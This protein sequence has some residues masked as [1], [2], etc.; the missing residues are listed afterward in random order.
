MTMTEEAG[1]VKVEQDHTVISRQAT[2]PMTLIEVALEQ[3]ADVEKLERLWELQQR[4]EANEAK[5]AF[6]AAM[7]GFRAECPSISKNATVSYGNG[8][9]SYKH[10]TLDHIIE[11]IKPTLSKFGLSHSWRVDQ[12]D[13]AIAVTCVVTHMQGHSEQTCMIGTPDTSG[14]KNAIQSIGSTTTYL[15][16]YTLTSLLGLA[17]GEDDDGAQSSSEP[18]A[19]VE[20][21][22]VAMI[23]S[24]RSK[25]ELKSLWANMTDEQRR[26]YH[27]EIKA[28]TS[29][30]TG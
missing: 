28:R 12:K 17:T 23:Q 2:T 21:D 3:N 8:R 24:A 16:R 14:S 20:G 19:G 13:G 27:D 30:L 9:T 6:D 15:Q 26:M 7:A 1:I 18:S 29:E 11:T 25:A 10:A 4:W 22:V 5:K